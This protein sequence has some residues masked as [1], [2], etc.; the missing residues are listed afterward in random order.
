MRAT[1]TIVVEVIGV[2]VV[3]PNGS[4]DEDR[5]EVEFE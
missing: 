2:T 5:R 1:G 4:H 3:I